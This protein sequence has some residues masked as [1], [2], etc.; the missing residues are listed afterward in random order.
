MVPAARSCEYART[1]QAVHLRRVNIMVRD[2]A[3]T[4]LFVKEQQH[5]PGS[6]DPVKPGQG[7]LPCSGSLVRCGDPM[8]LS[9][10]IPDRFLKC[11]E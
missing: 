9:T 1:S 11:E 3:S 5:G 4:E 7:A 2:F 8:G 10:K 6:Q